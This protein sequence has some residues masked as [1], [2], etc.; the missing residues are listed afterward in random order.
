MIDTPALGLKQATDL[1]IAV[2]AILLGEPDQGQT[3][4]IFVLLYRPALQRAARKPDNLACAP[5]R[6]TELLTRVDN[7]ITEL[8][9]AQAFGFKKSRLSLRISLSSSR[10]ATIFFRR[11]F[12]FSSAF[13]SDS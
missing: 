13:I 9:G 3:K 1:A 5:L 8:T 2:T 6:C 12:S 11:W 7:A 4:L 10:S